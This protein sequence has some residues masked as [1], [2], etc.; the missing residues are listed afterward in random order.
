MLRG[1]RTRQLKTDVWQ[2]FTVVRSQPQSSR[3]PYGNTAEIRLEK[4]AP[5]I[6]APASRF[7]TAKFRRRYHNERP[8]NGLPMWRKTPLSCTS[9]RELRR[10]RPPYPVSKSGRDRSAA[11]WVRAGARAGYP[12]REGAKNE[13]TAPP[14]CMRQSQQIRRV[15]LL[16]S[17]SQRF[18][19]KT[20]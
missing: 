6:A 3:S 5:P 11:K 8:C 10:A 2:H 20:A 7:A 19:K 14:F 9:N 18:Q 16:W 15:Y 12:I 1:V 4:G 17:V 13:T